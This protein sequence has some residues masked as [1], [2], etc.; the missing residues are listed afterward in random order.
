MTKIQCGYGTKHRTIANKWTKIVNLHKC[1]FLLYKM[2]MEMPISVS[3]NKIQ[4]KCKYAP[5]IVFNYFESGIQVSNMLDVAI[6]QNI[7]EKM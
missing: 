2:L 7:F 4:W 5:W 3:T 6:P 1:H